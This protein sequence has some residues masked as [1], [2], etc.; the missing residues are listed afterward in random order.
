EFVDRFLAARVTEAESAAFIRQPS[1]VVIFTLLAIQ[2]RL[3]DVKPA[4][5]PNTSSGAVP[6]YEKPAAKQKQGKQR[7]G[8][9]QG[10]PGSRRPPPVT[11]DRTRE[12]RLSRCPRAGASKWVRNR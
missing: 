12:Q 8:G 6:P 4:A 9:Q 3:G 2:A 10:H 1:E 5:G 7:R 11:P